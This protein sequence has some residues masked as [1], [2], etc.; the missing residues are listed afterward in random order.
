MKTSLRST[1][2]ATRLV[3]AVVA[4][5]LA[6]PV[7]ALDLPRNAT[8]TIDNDAGS[9]VGRGVV[10][11]DELEIEVLRGASGFATLTITTADGHTVSYDALFSGSGQV[12][13]VV[14]GE[15]VDLRELARSAGLEYEL[16]YEDR[17][18]GP[19]GGGADRDDDGDDDRDDDDR[20]DDDD[21]RDDRDDDD[22]DDDD[23]DDRDDD[24]DDRG[25]DRDDDDNDGDDNDDD[26]NDGDAT[27]E[28][29]DDDDDDRDD[30]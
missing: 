14:D 1:T 21:D 12:L 10:A 30:D 7:F 26:D 11:G 6:A 28:D 18:D 2:F 20:D 13:V 15:V 8:V 17:L 9:Q 19:N 24:R 5:A 22:R 29:D 27:D 23:R 4:L 3:A 25:D 16:E